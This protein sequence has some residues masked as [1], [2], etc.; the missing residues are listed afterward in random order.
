MKTIAWREPV[1]PLSRKGCIMKTETAMP[2]CR[3]GR[4]PYPPLTVIK[5][6]VIV[7]NLTSDLVAKILLR[8]GFSPIEVVEMFQAEGFSLAGAV[9]IGDLDRFRPWDLLPDRDRQ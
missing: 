8:N 9:V 4:K 2:P 3:R 7:Q 1:P 5:W 6:L